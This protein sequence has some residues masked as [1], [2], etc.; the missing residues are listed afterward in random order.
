MGCSATGHV[1]R[2]IKIDDRPSGIMT[3]HAYGIID[4]FEVEDQNMQNKR[5]THRL[6]R[7]QN[8][9]GHTEW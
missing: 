8:P 3:G 9:W 4:V 5:K 1:E 6:L 7:L 2:N